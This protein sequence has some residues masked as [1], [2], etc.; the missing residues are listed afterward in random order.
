MSM[1]ELAGVYRSVVLPDERILDILK[2]VDLTVA[3]GEHVSIVGRSGT[4]KSTLLYILGLLDAPTTG[5]YLLEGVP[6]GRLSRRART[7]R[8]G[9]DFG[10]VF[11]QFNLLPGRTALENVAAPLLYARGRQFWRRNR[12]AA[13]MLDRVGLGDRLDTMPE[14]LS[15]G[16]QQRI[17]IARALVRGPRVILADEPT[18]AL[19]VETGA[20]VMDLLDEVAAET[21]AALVTIT[22]DLAVAARAQRHYRLADGVLVP[23][24]LTPGGGQV[25]WMGDVPVGLAAN[26]PPESSDRALVADACASGVPSDPAADQ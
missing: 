8:R 3:S 17:A 15:G 14:R 23:I 5:E 1:I 13:D 25:D 2:G 18:G 9:E 19:D 21:G 22:H 6:V 7:R 24:H 26:V 11:Q 12:V 16:E 4:G 10:F 20:A